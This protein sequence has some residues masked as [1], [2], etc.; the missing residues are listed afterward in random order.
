MFSDGRAQA[1]RLKVSIIGDVMTVSLCGMTWAG[2]EDEF[3][4]LVAAFNA[5]REAARNHQTVMDSML[6]PRR[7]S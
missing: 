1:D 2:S 5:Q 3:D 7:K 4:E 6:P